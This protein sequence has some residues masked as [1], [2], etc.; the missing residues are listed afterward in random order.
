M[1]YEK[2]F[3][4]FKEGVG[5]GKKVVIKTGMLFIVKLDHLVQ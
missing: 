3:P 2:N 5:G 4:S 1:I